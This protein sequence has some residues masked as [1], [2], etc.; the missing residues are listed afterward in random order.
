MYFYKEEINNTNFFR[1]EKYLIESGKWAKLPP[2]SKAVFPV[3][4]WHCNKDGNAF[5][6][7]QTI[8]ILSGLSEKTVR[9]GTKGLWGFSGF[10]FSFYITKRGKRAKRYHIDLPTNPKKGTVFPFYK[11]IMDGGHWHLLNPTGK[12]L[13]PVMRNFG[14]FDIEQYADL[15]DLDFSFGDFDEVYPDRKYDLCEAEKSVL[16]ELA[17]I[18]ERSVDSALDNLEEFLLVE[19]IGQGTMWKVYLK[20]KDGLYYTRECLNERIEKSFGHA[21]K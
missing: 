10:N 18:S 2:A 15:E 8:A 3:I 13:Y 14:F 7:E 9:E 21:M 12:A 16:A 6:S 4:A 20:S 5:P 19:T 11:N 17:G 1:W